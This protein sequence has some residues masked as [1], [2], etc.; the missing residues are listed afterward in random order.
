MGAVG[1][2]DCKWVLGGCKLRLHIRAGFAQ[3]DGV[4]PYVAN[5][6]DPSLAEVTLN[7][8]IPLLGIRDDESPRHGKAA[9]DLRV[10][11]VHISLPRGKILAKSRSSDRS[12]TQTVPAGD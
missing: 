1:Q 3:V 11:R 8:K 5:F 6:H 7:R 9:G 4:A 10:A 12:R 2:G